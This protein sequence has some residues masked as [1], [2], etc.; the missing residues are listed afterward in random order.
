[1]GDALTGDG[2]P[3]AAGL[4]RE[5]RWLLEDVVG[6]PPGWARVQGRL[7][8]GGDDASI[9]SLRAPLEALTD[10]W[11][12]RLADRAPHQYVTG[13]AHW[14][15]MVLAVGPGVL[16]PRPETEALVDLAAAAAAAA[17]PAVRASPWADAGTGSGALALGLAA[18]L[19]PSV[20]TV[21]ATDA[22]ADAAAWARVNVARVEAGT[23]AAATRPRVA[24]VEG[25]WLAPVPGATT[26]GLG[27]IVSNPPYIP[28]HLLP[29]LQPEVRRHEPASALDGGG[30]GGVA[31][32]AGLLASVAGA[33]VSGGFFGCETHGHGQADLVAAALLG[34][35]GVWTSVSVVEDE[36]G[37]ARFVTAV[38][39]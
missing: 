8:A 4:A 25:D 13:A 29:T 20:G 18:V 39:R 9:V 10:G 26:R 37:V 36:R 27:G 31:A 28:S 15:D 17:P 19:P 11:S 23:A 24:V 3:D 38:R 5:L 33:L 1:V 30:D 7:G 2:G 14:R 32:Y 35:D 21:W 34:Q 6:D 22:S 12:A 16:V